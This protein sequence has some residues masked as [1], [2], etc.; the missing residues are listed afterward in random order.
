MFSLGL[1]LCLVHSQTV[2][3]VS[4]MSQ[5]LANNSY[6][7]LSLVGRPDIGG[8]DD[9]QCI[10]DLNTCCR[11]TDGVHRGDWYFPDG[12][13]L[14]FSSSTI[15]TFENRETQGVDIRRNSDVNSPTVGI[16]R[17]DIPTNAVHD[18]TDISV[19]D[20]VYVGLYNASGGRLISTNE[21]YIIYLINVHC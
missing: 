2:P 1:L 4:F 5:T 14:P 9:V 20:T 16:Y 3:Y 10:T 7:D 18:A 12:T 8:G 19:R 17:C 11:G 13:R 6:V 21:D 15:D